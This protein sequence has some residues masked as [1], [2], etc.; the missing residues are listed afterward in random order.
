MKIKIPIVSGERKKGRIDYRNGVA[1][2]VK[3]HFN[4]QTFRLYNNRGF[5]KAWI[6][7]VFCGDFVEAN[8]VK[9]LSDLIIQAHK[10]LNS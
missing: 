9:E 6:E 3:G 4:N 8:L 7:A 5:S 2:C 1:R 10:V